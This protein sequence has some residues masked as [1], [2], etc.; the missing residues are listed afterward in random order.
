MSESKPLNKVNIRKTAKGPED[1]IFEETEVN[2]E[3]TT[4]SMDKLLASAKVIMNG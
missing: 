4:E 1:W 3:S 2:L